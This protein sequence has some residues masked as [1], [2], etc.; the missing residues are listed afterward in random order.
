[1]TGLI[2]YTQAEIDP[3][4]PYN[5]L[6]VYNS[7]TNCINYYY[8]YSWFKTCGT[9]TPMP[10]QAIACDDQAFYDYTLSTT[11]AANTPY[12]GAGL[13]TVESG[14][15]G[16]F[17]NDTFPDGTFTGHPCTYYTLAWSISNICD[18]TTDQMDVPFFAMPTQ[19]IASNNQTIYDDTLSTSLTSNTPEVGAGLWTVL[20]G[21][22]GSID[23]SGDPGTTFSSNPCTAY[24]LLWSI[25][26]CYVTTYDSVDVYFLL[27][28]QMPLQVT[29]QLLKACKQP[30]RFLQIRL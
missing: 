10:S 19:A 27:H 1:M 13:W 2:S 16:S 14:E 30:L 11:L 28:P 15:G 23:N 8:S 5:G 17:S 3:M 12:V 4:T 6:T 26:S 20:S 24:I 7:I 21:D 18:T 9:C 25:S 22:G 29:A